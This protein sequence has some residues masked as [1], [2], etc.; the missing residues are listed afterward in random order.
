MLIGLLPHVTSFQLTAALIRMSD[1]ESPNIDHS[2]GWMERMM[3][4]VQSVVV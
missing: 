3:R 2:V 1:G 4:I